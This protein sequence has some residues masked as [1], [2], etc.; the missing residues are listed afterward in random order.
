MNKTELIESVSSTTDTKAEKVVNAV[1]EAF[2]A[3]LKKGGDITIKGFGSFSVKET[4]A[5]KGRNP[6]T[7]ESIS[8]PA[9]KKVSFKVSPTLKEVLK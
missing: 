4:A 9:G 8:I 3:E 2:V 5:R 1:F 6:K 7:G